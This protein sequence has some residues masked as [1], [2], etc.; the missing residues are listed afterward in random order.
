MRFPADLDVFRVLP[1]SCRDPLGHPTL[2]LNLAAFFELVSRSLDDTK[3]LVLWLDDTM[4]WYLRKIS[5]ESGQRTPVLQFVAIVN[6]Q[7]VNMSSMVRSN[8]LP[9]FRKSNLRQA[10]DLVT[11]YYQDVQPHYPGMMA[12]GEG[13]PSASLPIYSSD[14]LSLHSGPFVGALPDVEYSQVSDPWSTSRDNPPTSL[15]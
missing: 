14:S 12:A 2:V 6:V 15:G 4:R 8:R 11:W 5:K 10:T 9:S 3:D 7:G 13:F 1:P